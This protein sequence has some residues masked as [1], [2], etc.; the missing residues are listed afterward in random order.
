MMNENRPVGI[1]SEKN[2]P[3]EKKTFEKKA[4]SLLVSCELC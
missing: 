1:Q 4:S 2:Q 3:V